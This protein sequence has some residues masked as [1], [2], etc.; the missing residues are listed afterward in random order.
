MA[1]YIASL[2]PIIC[3]VLILFALDSLK[4]CRMKFLSIS[5]VCGIAVGLVLLTIFHFVSPAFPWMVPVIEELLKGILPVVLAGRRKIGF[6]VEGVTYGA[7]VGAG[8]ALVEN[9]TYASSFTDMGFFTAL[10]RGVFTALLHIGCTAI[11][12]AAA[13]IVVREL[14]E[15]RGRNP[16]LLIA[17]SFIPSILIHVFHNAVM[18]DH[19]Y[20]LIV[21]LLFFPLVIFILYKVD[22]DT[23]NNWMETMVENDISILACIHEGML[24]ET[25]AGKYLKTL[26]SR[27]SPEEIADI[28]CCLTLHLEMSVAAKSRLILKEMGLAERMDPKERELNRTKLLELQAITSRIGKRGVM[29]LSPII[30]IHSFDQYAFREI[31]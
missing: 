13:I 24:H 12:G 23:I 15:K 27:F 20:F 8:F 3:Y 25:N 5:A 19:P 9:I 2:I 7:T 10:Y 11:V 16:W 1:T 17:L 18:V 22:S 29:A 31:M 6:F 21:H 14:R 30:A 28:M 4:I 26:H